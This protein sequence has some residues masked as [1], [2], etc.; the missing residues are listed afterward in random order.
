MIKER[1]ELLKI[2]LEVIKSKLILYSGGFGGSVA[3]G[4]REEL[5][6]GAKY[7]FA[8]AAFILFI[9]ILL[10]LSRFGRIVKDVETLEKRLDDV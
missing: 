6:A 10:N 8:V 3:L 4:L 7:D 2:K 9:G 5:S 1:I